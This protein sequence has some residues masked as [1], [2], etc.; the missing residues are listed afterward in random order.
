MRLFIVLALA[1]AGLLLVSRRA[2]AAAG[3]EG[4]RASWFSD[5][6]ATL[7]NLVTPTLD[8]LYRQYGS[9]FG[10]DWRLVKAIAQ[11]ESGENPA[12]VNERDNESIGVMQVLCRP[13][14]RGGC[15][16]RLNVDGWPDTTRE[17]LLDA[18]W[19]IYIGAQ[20]LAWNIA[21]FGVAKGIAVYNAWDQHTAPTAGPFKNQ[22]YV[23]DV[24][25]KARALG[26]SE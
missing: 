26:W 14:G 1:L 18:D 7:E 23:N 20:I 4:A 21:T 3:D 2:Q 25:S 8:D 12:A 24:I 16:N 5:A 9:A 11:R 10:V 6:A 17:K 15:S 22:A 13:D 19:N